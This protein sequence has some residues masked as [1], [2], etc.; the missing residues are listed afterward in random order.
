MAG[1]CALRGDGR[2]QRSS[3][4][5]AMAIDRLAEGVKVGLIMV[6]MMFLGTGHSGAGLASFQ[7]RPPAAQI[8]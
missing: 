2:Q 1:Q 3:E 4:L 5:A 8:A 7:K 6:S